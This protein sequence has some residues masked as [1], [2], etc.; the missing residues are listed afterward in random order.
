MTAYVLS[1]FYPVSDKLDTSHRAGWA[2]Y[3]AQELG[4]V[5]LTTSTMTEVDH[6]KR[7]DELLCYHGMEFK[8]QLNLQSGLTDEILGRVKRLLEAKKRGAKFTSLDVPMPQYGKLLM[9]RG[10]DETSGETL[11]KLCRSTQF[12]SAPTHTP[13]T[14]IVGDS[15]AL[16]QYVPGSVILRHDSLTLWGALQRNG[17]GLQIDIAILEHEMG[18]LTLKNTKMVF[19]YGNIDIRHHLAR[20]D[21]PKAKV[22]ELVTEYMRHLAMVAK[23][24]KPSEIEVVLPLPIEDESRPIPKSGYYKG[25][26]F[27]GDWHTRHQIRLMMRD[28]LKRQTK[29]YGFTTYEHPRH[30]IGKDGKL[31]FEVMEKPRSVH[32]RPAEYRLVHEG[33]DWHV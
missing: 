10:M 29:K 28:E 33:Q 12:I 31:T 24:K 22:K 4:A 9:E 7:G 1:P 23:D 26:P 3:L 25:T 19:Y 16:S 13:K 14:V 8:G 15:H 17:S 6:L 20:F 32:I 27:F 18:L 11:E 5:L 30:F 21:D 2:R